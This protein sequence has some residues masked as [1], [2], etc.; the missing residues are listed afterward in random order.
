M[1]T[2][3]SGDAARIEAAVAAAAGGGVRVVQVREPRL[4][5]RA[6]A[7]LCDRLRPLL[8]AV[9]GVVIVN[10]RADVA[11]AGHADGVHL[12]HRSLAAARVRAFL[13]DAWIG[14]SAHDERSIAGAREAGAD[15]VSLS[16]VFATASKPG[17]RPLGATVASE[18]TARAGLPVV[19]LGG[20]D[21]DRL[22]GVARVANL[23]GVAALSAFADPDHARVNAEALGTRLL[24][25]FDPTWTPSA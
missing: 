23:A 8:Q 10:D 20:I 1:I 14:V 25:M 22:L 7:A 13:R 2:D 18:W 9:G 19:W 6:V 4:S 21:A 11:A 24:A 12:G 17:S 16:P 3:G 5:A 15:Y